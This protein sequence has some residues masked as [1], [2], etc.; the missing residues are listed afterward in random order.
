[1]KKKSSRLFRKYF[2]AFMAILL[3]SFAFLGTAMLAL[4]GQFWIKDR[5]APLVEG[6]RQTAAE[7]TGLYA[8]GYEGDRLEALAGV[9]AA[10]EASLEAE[11]LLFDARG[12][13]VA[14]AE[15]TPEGALCERHSVMRAPPNIYSAALFGPLA[16][17]GTI[18]GMFERQVL[19]AA[20]PFFIEGGAAGFVLAAQP[21]FSGHLID[22]LRGISRLFL[23]SGAAALALAFLVV[24]FI[25]YRLVRPLGDMARATRQY[26]LGN[27]GYRVQAKG[28]NELCQL[29]D[30]FNS[31]A[32]SLAT[33]EGSRR[34][35]VANVSHEL[36]TPM[37][38]IGGFIDGMLDGTI[39][40]AQHP[41]YLALVSEEVKRLS[42]LVTGMLN[43]SKIEDGELQLNLKPFDI[44]EL[45]FTTILRFEQIISRKG[46]ELTGLDALEPVVLPGDRDMLTQVFYNLIDNAVKFTPPGGR[47]EFYAVSDK[48][49]Y[50]FTLRNTGAGIPSEELSRIFE[51]FY[52]TD[53]SR[54]FDV[55]GAGLG[56]YLAKTIVTMH[57]GA[58]CAESDGASYAQF[59]VE[60]PV[61]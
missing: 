58:I 47:L 45:L 38:T 51:R 23:L 5:L 39:P 2:V 42:R 29:A 44:N 7:V 30:A 22:Y 17:S 49:N 9:L 50:T 20:E 6:A 8:P 35:F 53:K 10:R 46:L 1:M 54:S 48:E 55:K 37:T 15:M 34:S 59:R 16:L 60:L 27:F 28:D 19:Y 41:K 3:G 33:L 32:I 13:V 26:A 18:E 14:C 56:L 61:G 52:K 4:S 36:K 12:R 11:A 31:M 21:F 24:Y 25:S 57:G 40:A 43:L